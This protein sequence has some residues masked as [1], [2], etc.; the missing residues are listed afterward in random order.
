ML[1]FDNHFKKGANMKRLQDIA[2]VQVGF[3]LSRTKATPND[4]ANYTYKTLSI[5]AFPSSGVEMIQ[6]YENLHI[7]SE[8]ISDTYFTQEG[9]VLIRLRE[10]IRS[11]FVSQDATGLL[12]SSLV[13]IVRVD[14]EQILGEFLA[15]YLNSSLPQAYFQAKVRG[16]TIP[17]IR[18][19]DLKELEIPLPAL[20][21]QK[22]IVALMQESD[23]ELSLLK[24][25]ITQKS[26]LNQQIFK[27][28]LSKE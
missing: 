8:K 18:V 12:I 20:Q 21:R 27:T 24:E 11:I 25:M 16:T 14:R 7:S 3:T 1:S 28:L 15:Y 19:S 4:L 2:Q 13:V 6:G 5:N 17:M 26:L 9:D 22:Q 10:P 23:R